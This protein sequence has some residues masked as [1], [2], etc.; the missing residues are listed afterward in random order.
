M[1]PGSR[2]PRVIVRARDPRL[3]SLLVERLSAP[4]DLEVLAANGEGGAPDALIEATGEPSG[5]DHEGF[6]APLLTAREVE[7][8]GLLADGLAN[9]E[10]GARLGISAHTAKFHVESAMH[11]LHAANRA[12]AVRQ[13]IRHGL[14]GL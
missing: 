10:I 1:T 14:I 5:P 9:K 3:Q 4:G 12:E 6:A 7:V 2:P 8:L 13:G 11:K